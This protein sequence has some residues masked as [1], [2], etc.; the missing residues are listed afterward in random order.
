M[1][2]GKVPTNAWR[3]LNVKAYA[4]YDAIL[5]DVHEV[6][7]FSD[8]QRLKIYAA[9]NAFYTALQNKPVKH[10]R[11][12]NAPLISDQSDLLLR[13]PE[14]YKRHI[15]HIDHIIEF[16][17][18]GCNHYRNARV[19]SHLENTS[20]NAAARPAANEF[21]VM[22]LE[23]TDA[24]LE[25]GDT[26]R[27]VANTLLSL[28]DLR[29]LLSTAYV[30][31]QHVR[32]RNYVPTHPGTTIGNRLPTVGAMTKDDFE[33]IYYNIAQESRG[34]KKKGKV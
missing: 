10:D 26:L 25:D 15:A 20:A 5:P 11:I 14:D 21:E 31:G 6:A 16:R 7:D 27:C 19:L 17:N 9:N 30:E 18:W 1:R 33:A 13:R 2:I 24:E 22:C 29:T 28:A 12:K 4:Q 32:G 34:Q 3:Q 8:A 23:T